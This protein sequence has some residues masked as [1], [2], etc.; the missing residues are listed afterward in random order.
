MTYPILNRFILVI[1]DNREA[2]DL[3]VEVLTLCG[4]TAIAAYNGL[5]GI[6]L[7]E[8]SKP[9]VVLLDLTMPGMD[10]FA[11]AKKLREWST[12]S[13]TVLVAFT[14]L[15]DAHTIA[16]V[17]EESFDF[18]LAKPAPVRK[19]MHVISQARNI[20]RSP[21]GLSLNRKTAAQVL[22]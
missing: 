6:L 3:M 16:R 14:A 9:D 17:A 15:S 19:V 5:E 20:K 21:P 11:V 18:H 7:A 2:A 12:F 1:D 10:G 22:A 8:R 13:E 4:H